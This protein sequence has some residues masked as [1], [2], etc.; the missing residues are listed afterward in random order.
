MYQ[1]PNNE[2]LLQVR[3]FATRHLQEYV[4]EMRS[5]SVFITVG[6]NPEHIKVPTF[7]NGLHHGRQSF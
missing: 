4:Q 7:M 1:L 6:L 3:F 2:V 5:L